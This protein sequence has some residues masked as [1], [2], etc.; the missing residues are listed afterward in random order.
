MKARRKMGRHDHLMVLVIFLLLLCGIFLLP[1][2]LQLRSEEPRRA[3]V[4]ME[5][6]FSGDYLQPQLNGWPYYNKPPFF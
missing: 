3:I 1:A 5:M 4:A 6:I 2:Q